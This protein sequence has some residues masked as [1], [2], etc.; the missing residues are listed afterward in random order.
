MA[1]E[2]LTAARALGH[3]DEDMVAVFD[4]LAKLAGRDRVAA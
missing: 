1:N 4:V 2:L 3:G